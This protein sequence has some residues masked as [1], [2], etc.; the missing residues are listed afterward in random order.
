MRK[1]WFEGCREEEGRI[2]QGYIGRRGEQ[3]TRQIGNAPE[4]RTRLDIAEYWYLH[5][6]NADTDN[7]NF[8]MT[9]HR[10]RR[11]ERDGIHSP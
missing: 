8:S 2:G 1:G 9:P 10:Q 11:R 7:E 3:R 4:L 5:S 6:L